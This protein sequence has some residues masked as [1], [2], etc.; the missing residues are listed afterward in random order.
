MNLSVRKIFAT[1]MVATLLP[2]ISLA[3]AQGASND[4]LATYAALAKLE[5]NLGEM[6]AALAL[7][8]MNGGEGPYADNYD[9]DEGSVYGYLRALNRLD[10]SD[11]MKADLETFRADF[12]EVEDEG[13]EVLEAVAE[14]KTQAD[15]Q[16]QLNDLYDRFQELDEVIDA[17]LE[18]MLE[19][20][21]VT[22]D[23]SKDED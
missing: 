16:Q 6:S 9:E 18:R 15:L 14:G 21:S 10:I 13:E 17:H 8:V 11:E 2:T 1:L 23:T 5:S 4:T 19:E 20:N 12:K 3:N 7:H 22:L